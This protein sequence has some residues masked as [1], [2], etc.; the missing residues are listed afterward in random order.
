MSKEELL[1]TNFKTTYDAMKALEEFLKSFD[2]SKEKCS[3][4]DLE[5]LKVV[6]TRIYE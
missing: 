2:P 3:R 5:S 1:T 6:G 4:G